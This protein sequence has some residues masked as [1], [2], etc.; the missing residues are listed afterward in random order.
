MS[1]EVLKKLISENL[2][3]Y[4]IAKELNCGQSTVRYWLRKF[5]LN[6]NLPSNKKQF[7]EC[8]NGKNCVY[9]E[10][11]LTG[12]KWK[13]CG[14]SCKCS[15]H[16]KSNKQH[17]RNCYERQL[18]VSKERKLKLIDMSGGK[19]MKC[20]YNKN[21]AALQ[22]HHKNPENKLFTLDSRKLSNTRWD[23]I[24]KEWEKCELLCANC[25]SEEHYPNCLINGP[26]GRI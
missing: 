24:V 21:Y 19:C 15:F 1:E 22:F 2:S 4:Q 26:W 11:P 18:R 9:C 14:N 7:R 20:G 23:S 10:K 13:F 17:N 5:G 16:F 8:F 3:T 6:T 25:H 12:A